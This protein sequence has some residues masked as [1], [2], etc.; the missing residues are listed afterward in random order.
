MPGLHDANL[1]R[2]AKFDM[3]QV[4]KVFSRD[5]QISLR[6]PRGEW[7]LVGFWTRFKGDSLVCCALCEHVLAAPFTMD[8][9]HCIDFIEIFRN[10]TIL[11]GT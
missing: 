10:F 4:F 8:Q 9:K 6:Q 11:W 2:E 1:M 3:I 7:K 5:S